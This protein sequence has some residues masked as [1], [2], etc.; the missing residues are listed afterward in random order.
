MRDSGIFGAYQL[1][2]ADGDVESFKARVIHRALTPP[3]ANDYLSSATTLPFNNN[4]YPN[5]VN[6]R[7]S[8]TLGGFRPTTRENSRMRGTYG[9]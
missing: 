5:A 3:T 9:P 8:T 1:Y 4:S 6:S 7:A 2:L